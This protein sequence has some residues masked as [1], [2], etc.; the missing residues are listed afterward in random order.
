MRDTIS[1]VLR[2]KKKK[3][4]NQGDYFTM[5]VSEVGSPGSQHSTSLAELSPQPPYQTRDTL[6]RPW[7]SA[8]VRLR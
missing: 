4:G 3:S 5:V 1:V 7:D 2:L 6:P 8:E